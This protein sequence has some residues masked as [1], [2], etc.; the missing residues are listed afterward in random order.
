VGIATAANWS[1]AIIAFGTAETNGAIGG[2]GAVETMD[3]GIIGPPVG[4]RDDAD[5]LC[6]ATAAS[7][8]AFNNLEVHAVLCLTSSD[9]VANM[10]GNFAIPI[11]EP[12]ASLGDV[13]VGRTWTNFIGGTSLES[14]LNDAAVVSTKT[15]IWMGCSKEAQTLI[16]NTC[17][18]WTDN[19][20]S[21][22]VAGDAGVDNNA[23]GS[24]AAADTTASDWLQA[25]LAAACSDTKPVLCVAY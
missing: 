21:G 1:V 4:L 8:S 14:T 19:G 3:G 15:R 12:V 5:G 7:N 10:A 16:D 9:S 20:S 17:D 22:P 2:G 13:L 6:A 11:G 23:K 18:N 24:V 25:P